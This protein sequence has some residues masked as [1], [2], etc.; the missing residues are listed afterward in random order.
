LAANYQRVHSSI[1]W[2]AVNIVFMQMLSQTLCVLYQSQY[3][4][5]KLSKISRL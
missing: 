3:I 1:G 4:V 5:Y 2:L